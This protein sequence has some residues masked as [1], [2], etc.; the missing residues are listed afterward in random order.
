MRSISRQA[1]AALPLVAILRG[2]RPDEAE[3]V[4]AALVAAGFRIIEVPLNSPDP[5]RSIEALAERFGDDALIGS[6]TVMSPAAARARRSRP[7]AGSS[8]CRTPI[9]Q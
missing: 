3:A 1:M 2:I 4:G 5:F 6:G 7:A 9:R 8:S